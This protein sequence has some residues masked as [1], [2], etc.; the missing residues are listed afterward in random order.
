MNIHIA[1]QGLSEDIKSRLQQGLAGHTCHFVPPDDVQE[2]RRRANDADVIF[3]NVPADWLT[4]ATRLRWLQL[5]SAGA[6]DYIPLLSNPDSKLIITNLRDFYGR[7]VA[8]VVMAGLLAHFRRLPS[9]LAAQTERKW[10]KPVV[11]PG[12]NRLHGRQVLILGKG[13][14]GSR[15]GDIL[16]SLECSVDHFA[17][18]TAGATLR[19][20]AELE[21]RLP[22]ADVVVNTLP[23][24]PATIN[25]LDAR[26]LDLFSPSAIFANAGRGSI[27]DENA[28]IERL[29][30][31]RIAGAVLDVTQEEPLPAD[32]PLWQ[33]PN[34]ILTQ[35]T[36][37]RFPDEIRAKVDVFLKNLKRFEAGEPLHGQLDPRRGY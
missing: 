24:T 16:R 20:L 1:V 36:G 18:S 4:G 17:R 32:N 27:V 28:L 11:E 34:V 29:R 3:G 19:T 2:A 31:G 21:E 9:L 37:G 8:E 13:S 7:A 14:I 10:I 22:R 12:I 33:L 23:H 30:D 15:L 35:H 26:R 5:D 6:D 25:L